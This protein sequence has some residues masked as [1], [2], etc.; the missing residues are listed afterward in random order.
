MLVQ[1]S[2][3]RDIP[4]YIAYMHHFRISLP[5]CTVEQMQHVL[6]KL[7]AVFVDILPGLSINETTN[8]RQSPMTTHLLSNWQVDI[9]GDNV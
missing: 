7:F 9:F 4:E 3:C 2:K 5:V 1:V 6:L 8:L